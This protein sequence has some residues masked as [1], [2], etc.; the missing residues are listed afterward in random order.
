MRS[1]TLSVLIVLLRGAAFGVENPFGSVRAK[2][3]TPVFVANFDVF[4]HVLEHEG[5]GALALVQKGA[6][7]VS[8]PVRVH[9][10]SRG[11]AWGALAGLGF[12][13]HPPRSEATPSGCEVPRIGLK[14]GRIFCGHEVEDITTQIA[15][16]LR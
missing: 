16:E 15:G 2:P 3:A 10:V 7:V 13:C 6:V 8:D 5:H 9:D 14:H 1:L 12:P 11:N 4:G